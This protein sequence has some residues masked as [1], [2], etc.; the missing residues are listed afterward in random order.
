TSPT[1]YAAAVAY[2]QSYGLTVNPSPDRFFLSVTGRPEA[3]G[4]AFGTSFSLYSNEGQVFF[5]H[6]SAAHLPAGIPWAGVVGLGNESAPL[7]SIGPLQPVELAPSGTSCPLA[8]FL[9]PCQ[10]RSEYNESLLLANGTNGSGVQIGVVDTYDGSEPQSTLSTDLAQFGRSF[11]VPVG[12]V[13]YLYP[14]PTTQD[15]NA[16]SNDWGTEDALDLEWARAMAPA[17]TID[18]TFAPNSGAGLYAAVDWLVAHQAVDVLSLSWGEPD[19]GIFNDAACVSACNASSDG[20]YALLH[21]ILMAAAA[22]G[23]G[24]FAASGDCGAADGTEG[25]STNYPASDPWV[26]GVGGTVV[27]GTGTGNYSVETGWSG[28]VNGTAGCNNQGG[29]GG[30][31]S[32]YPKPLWQTGPGVPAGEADRGV[33]DVAAIAGSR[34]FVVEDGNEI[35][36]GGTSASTPMWAGVAALADQFAGDRLGFLDPSLYSLFRSTNY[37]AAFHDV[38]HG[39]NGYYAGPGW[40]PVTGIGTPDVGVLVADLA[41]SVPARENLSV[42]MLASP[43]YGS[44]PLTVRFI[45]TDQGGSRG[46]PLTDLVFGDGNASLASNSSFTYTYDRPGVYVAQAV[47]YDS[48]GNSSLSPPITIVVGS[49]LPLGVALNVSTS[50]PAVGAGVTFSTTATGGTAPYQF[51]YG[52]GDGTY[53]NWTDTSVVSH[54]YG[55]AAAVCADVVVRDA[56]SAVDGGS[57][58]LVPLTVGSARPANCTEPAPL[59]I[60]FTSSI[61][62]ADLPGDLPLR[63]SVQ[64]GMGPVAVRLVSNDSY[65]SACQCGIFRLPGSHVVKAYASDSFDEWTMA[66]LNVTLYPALTGDFQI[67][68][69]NGTAPLSVRFSS[70]LSGGHDANAND[71]TWTFGD[72][73]ETVGAIVDHTYTTPGS[74]LAL[75]RASDDGGGVASEAFLID[76]LASNGTGQTILTANVTPAFDVPAGTPILFRA[77]ASGDGGP[78]VFHWEMGANVSAFGNTVEESFT[79]GCGG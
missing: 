2:F 52:F 57:S 74:Y 46:Y 34:V 58:S 76:V 17:A 64:G 3:M 49:G 56:A 13:R 70:S 44:A 73:T 63:T 16:T 25:L 23:I 60:G 9:T 20:S 29:S 8:S 18:M 53:L 77:T 75:G 40:D 79:Q 6:A 36:A 47:V 43:R 22:E 66:E 45:W 55:V 67:S 11:G 4:A 59:R 30:G 69:T 12:T 31:F 38:T 54:T 24:V 71:T 19:V 48:S 65:A 37:S 7:P 10:V 62:S 72:G 21:P 78:Y 35:A 1:E 5:S 15:L 41:R 27:S 14:V 50:D 42:A 28:D 61:L 51:Y 33:P 32:P 68:R 26:T 39:W